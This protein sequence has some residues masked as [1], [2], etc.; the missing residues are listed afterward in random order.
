MPYRTPSGT[1][2]CSVVEGWC[3]SRRGTGLNPGISSPHRPAE[4]PEGKALLALLATCP[5]CAGSGVVDCP[6]PG[7]SKYWSTCLKCG[8]KGKLRLVSQDEI[9]QAHARVRALPQAFADDPPQLQP[10][11]PA[12]NQE[13]QTKRRAR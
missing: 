12:R 11:V 9:N 2:R 8:G 5:G 4:T 13:K 3:Q 1:W 7:E 6:L 10:L